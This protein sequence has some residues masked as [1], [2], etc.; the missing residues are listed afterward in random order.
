MDPKE[1]QE[2]V[3]FDFKALD[4]DKIGIVIDELTVR[5]NVVKIDENEN[6]DPILHFDYDI[7][8]DQEDPPIDSVVDENFEE[9]LGMVVE[10]LLRDQYEQE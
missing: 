5:I 4:N 2:G 6:G 3:D 10:K 8:S 9:K 7:I 1:L